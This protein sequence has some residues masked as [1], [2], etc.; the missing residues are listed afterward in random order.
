M[1]EPGEI[2]PEV[3]GS[4]NLALIARAELES[5]LKL[6]EVIV[7]ADERLRLPRQVADE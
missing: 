6:H 4:I 3:C 1:T 5:R 2:H 7:W